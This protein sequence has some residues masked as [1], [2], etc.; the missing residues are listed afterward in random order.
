MLQ[1]WR[2]GA[3]LKHAVQVLGHKGKQEQ[4]ASYNRRGRY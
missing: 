2:E 1:V 3:L 4:G